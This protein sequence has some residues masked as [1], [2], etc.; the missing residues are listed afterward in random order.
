MRF[1]GHRTDMRRIYEATDLVVR[2]SSTEGMP[3]AVR[4]ALG[5]DTAG[6]RL[7]TD[8][9]PGS[10]RLDSNGCTKRPPRRLAGGQRAGPAKRT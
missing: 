5:H 2:C 10:A 6:V 1:L 8:S 4:E 9:T 3:D 7:R